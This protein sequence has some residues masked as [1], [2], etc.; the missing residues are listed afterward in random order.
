MIEQT[1]Q[2]VGNSIIAGSVYALVGMSFVLGYRVSRFFN[3][4]HAAVFTVG[5]YTGFTL[6]RTARIPLPFAAV[7]AGVV[8]AL[9]GCALEVAIYRPLRHRGSSALGLLVAS[10]GL[11]VLVQ[12]TVS[13]LFGD[14]VRSILVT[15]PAP[16]L[17]ILGARI[18]PVQLVTVA[19]AVMVLLITMGVLKWTW[20]GRAFRTVACD[21]EL[22]QVCGTDAEAVLLRWSAVASAITAA[23]GFLLGLDVDLVPTMGLQPLMAGIVAMIVGGVASVPGTAVGGLIVGGAQQFGAWKIGYQWQDAI[24]F[25]ILLIF[26][27]LRPHGVLGQ[28]SSMAE[29]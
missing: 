26:M 15:G 16:G 29:V 11:Y 12:N 3:L 8:G 22:A 21:A 2:L 17:R 20:F 27:L 14:E 7:G 24:A 4:A 18:T 25:G 5:A 28:K 23:A 1:S 9:L 6:V 19:V 10:L 13:L